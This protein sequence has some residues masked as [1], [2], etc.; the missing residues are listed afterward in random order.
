MFV[1]Q[2]IHDPL[3]CTVLGVGG[4]LLFSWYNMSVMTLSQPVSHLV[5]QMSGCE[6]GNYWTCLFHNLEDCCE[7]KSCCPGLKTIYTLQIVLEIC[8]KVK[9]FPPLLSLIKWRALFLYVRH[10]LAQP[11]YKPWEVGPIL[12]MKKLRF[13]NLTNVTHFMRARAAIGT[14][15][16]LQCSRSHRTL[17]YT[18]WPEYSLFSVGCLWHS[19][20]YPV[21]PRNGKIQ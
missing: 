20:I 15:V 18:L 4:S 9:H 2:Q 19:N 5:H 13:N 1:V 7:K 12:Q 6:S 10:E 14:K 8:M 21:A 17:N 11:S 16:L 3:K